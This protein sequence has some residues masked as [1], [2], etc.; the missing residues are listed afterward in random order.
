MT[1]VS[2]TTA[3]IMPFESYHTTLNM[4]TGL[5][6]KTSLLFYWLRVQG[7][8]HIS[9][10]HITCL[11][12]STFHYYFKISFCMSEWHKILLRNVEIPRDSLYLCNTLRFWIKTKLFMDACARRCD[13]TQH[14]SLLIRIRI[15]LMCWNFKNHSHYEQAVKSCYFQ[16][17]CPIYDN[18][19]MLSFIYDY[20][21]ILCPDMKKLEHIYWI[22]HIHILNT[23]KIS[24]A[25]EPSV[26][27]FWAEINQKSET[28]AKYY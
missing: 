1:R 9:S 5:V 24:T 4:I 12:G 18:V 28:C 27:E 23:F 16:R 21:F 20:V 3:A 2:C 11:Y 14:F 13:N 25:W 6:L 26:F 17:T 8:W 10:W 19:N 22:Y 7:K 15:R